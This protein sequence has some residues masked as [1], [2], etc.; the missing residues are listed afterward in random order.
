M[1]GAWAAW[2]HGSVERW[3]G[4]V[5]WSV[6]L[7]ANSNLTRSKRS[8][9]KIVFKCSRPLLCARQSSVHLC[10]DTHLCWVLM[11]YSTCTRLPFA[12]FSHSSTCCTHAC[13]VCSWVRQCYMRG[14]GV[15]QT[16]EATCSLGWQ[17]NS[18]HSSCRMSIVTI[19]G[20]R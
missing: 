17:G 18:I 5:A 4:M 11:H 9:R 7:L 13:A 2:R 12:G 8:E 20:H 1:A 6:M 19:A 15:G 3:H 10:V 16:V 14:V